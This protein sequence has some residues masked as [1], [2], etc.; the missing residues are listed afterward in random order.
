MMPFAANALAGK[1]G[2][3]GYEEG[4]EESHAISE[5]MAR[6]GAEHVLDMDEV[7]LKTYRAEKR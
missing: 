1:G 5:M 7:N 6:H 3:D 2:R 4:P